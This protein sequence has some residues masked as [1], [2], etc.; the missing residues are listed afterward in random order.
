MGVEKV[1]PLTVR[2]FNDTTQD[3]TTRFLDMCMMTGRGCGTAVSVFTK[4][5]TVLCNFQISWS[6]CV[7]VD[8]ASVNLGRRNSIMTRVKQKVEYWY[9]MEYPYYLVHK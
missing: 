8:S 4:I 9:F 2:N 7:G 3:V 5:N 6:N 1:N